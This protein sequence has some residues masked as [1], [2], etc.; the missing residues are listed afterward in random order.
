[1]ANGF[2]YLYQL[3]VSISNFRVVGWCFPFYSNF[4]R[5]ICKQTVETLIRRRDLWRLILVCT[6][7]ICLQ[8][9]ARLIW[10]N[11]PYLF[12]VVNGKKTQYVILNAS[13]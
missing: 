5:S 11:A 6:V 12:I 13:P 1:M 3:D 8:K 2:S 7:C 4:E 10:V 9:D